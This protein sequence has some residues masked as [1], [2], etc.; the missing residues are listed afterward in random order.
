MLQLS[1][2]QSEIRLIGLRVQTKGGIEIP[3]GA[4]VITGVELR[5]SLID[6]LRSIGAVAAIIITAAVD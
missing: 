5:P 2:A 6:Q 3:A 4:G 1:P